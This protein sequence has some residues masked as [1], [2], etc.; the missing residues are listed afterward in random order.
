MDQPNSRRY[1]PRT[2]WRLPAGL[3]LFAVVTLPF[4]SFISGFERG[5]VLHGG[6]VFLLALGA[7]AAM[8]GLGLGLWIA[9]RVRRLSSVVASVFSL[10]VAVFWWQVVFLP[11]IQGGSP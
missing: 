11:M 1:D 7:C 5:S 6:L 8:L 10:A 2:L 9:L 4:A 3:S